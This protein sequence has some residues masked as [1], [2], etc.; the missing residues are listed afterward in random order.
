LVTN[1]LTRYVW[2]SWLIVQPTA[3]R[4][5]KSLDIIREGLETIPGYTRNEIMK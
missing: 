1:T 4:A 3:E 2:P 5:K